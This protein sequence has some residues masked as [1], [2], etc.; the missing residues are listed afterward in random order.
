MY[1]AFVK[2]TCVLNIVHSRYCATYLTVI[3]PVTDFSEMERTFLPV[4]RLMK[5]DNLFGHIVMHIA[6]FLF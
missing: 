4:K 1:D 2:I 5:S 6:N 3:E